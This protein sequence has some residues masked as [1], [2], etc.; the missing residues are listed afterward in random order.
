MRIF[1]WITL[2]LFM[3]LPLFAQ[4]NEKAELEKRKRQTLQEIELLNRQYNEIKKGK[5][6]SLGQ[7]AVIQK[8][9]ELRNNVIANINSQINVIDRSIN[10]SYR[11][12]RILQKDLDT[13]RKNYAKNV[14]YAYKNRSNYDFLNF[15]FSSTNFNDAIRR[16]AYMRAYRSY[17][18]QQLEAIRKTETLYKEKIVQLTNNKKEKSAV[19]VDQTTEMGELLKDKKEQDEVV[20]KFKTREKEL[21]Q[22]LAAK[23]KQA[24]QLQA[25]ITAIVNREIAAAKKEAEA[26]AKAEKERMRK[27]REEADR[28]AKANAKNNPTA[29]VVKTNPVVKKEEPVK[30]QESYLEYNKEDLALGNS[31]EGSKGRLLFPVDNG[32]VSVPYGSYTI[33]GTQLKGYQEFITIASPV[34]TPVKAVFDGEVA[35]VTDVGG[36]LTIAIRH[37]KYFTF[38]SNLTSVAV[39]KGA[40]VKAGQVLGRVGTD[41]EGEGS[42]EFILTRET[43]NLNPSGWL[44][45]R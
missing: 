10:K 7:L 30:K 32:Y 8:K 34:G 3:S 24:Q 1:I 33:P 45:G 35:S 22:L 2:L 11:E 6:V 36:A 39:S 28:I 43:T 31:F 12:M 26:R 9:I 29:P 15:L 23:K 5:K 27:E 4:Q 38:Y 37:G 17:R 40:N 18:A 41:L 16:I 42:I 13:L 19:L 21:N 20:N 14:V 25:S 44:R